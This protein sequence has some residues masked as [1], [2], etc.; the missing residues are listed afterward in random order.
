MSRTHHHRSQKYSC[1]IPSWFTSMYM[2]KPEKAE[3]KQWET[4]MKKVSLQDIEDHEHPI[5]PGKVKQRYY[6]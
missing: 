1:S 4:K 3:V 6:W 2:N 5:E